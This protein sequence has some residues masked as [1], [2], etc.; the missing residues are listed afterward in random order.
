MSR[1]EN[2]TTTLMLVR[3]VIEAGRL[4]PTVG[5]L[6][7]ALTTG[8][9]VVAL[10]YLADLQLRIGHMATIVTMLRDW[11]RTNERLKKKGGTWTNCNASN[12]L[13]RSCRWH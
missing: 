3:M 11:E 10:D 12:A 5:D 2:P 1:S 6:T 9:Y 13:K 8:S 7:E 4:G